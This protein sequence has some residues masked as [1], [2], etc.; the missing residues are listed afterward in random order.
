M[1]TGASLLVRRHF[2]AV[3][4]VLAF[5]GR[6]STWD[7]EAEETPEEIENVAIVPVPMFNRATLRALAYA[8]SVCPSVV[9][10]HVAPTVEEGDRFRRYWDAWGNHVPLEVIESPY[11][12]IVP[13]T[14]AYVE[15]L[16]AQR[17]ELTLTVIVPELVVRHRWERHLHDGDAARLRRALRPLGKVVVT[18]VPFHV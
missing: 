2:D 17:P 15:A 10:L 8:S 3:G 14:V 5:G 16:H 13:P 7:A 1:F 12:A 6:S 4:D 9:A 18:S 11:R